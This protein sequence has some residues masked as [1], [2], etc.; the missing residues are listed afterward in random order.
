MKKACTF[1]VH[2]SRLE[3]ANASLQGLAAK[4][5]LGNSVNVGFLEL[6]TPSLETAIE[7]HIK[8]GATKI[9][10]L[11]LFLS[12]GRHLIQDIPP[13]VKEIQKKHPSVTLQVESFLGE[14][15]HFLDIITKWAHDCLQS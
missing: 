11:P 10:I 14:H 9:H 15:P 2:G 7:E 6:G 3:S 13:L 8:T 5:K 1:F 12:P 4:T